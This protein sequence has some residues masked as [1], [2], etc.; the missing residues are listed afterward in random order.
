MTYEH[1]QPAPR[2]WLHAP[3][4]TATGSIAETTSGS[5]LHLVTQFSS[6]FPSHT[7]IPML[8][9][10][11]HT[12]TAL[13]ENSQMEALRHLSLEGRLLEKIG[14]IHYWGLSVFQ[15]RRKLQGKTQSLNDGWFYVVKTTRK[16]NSLLAAESWPCT[17]PLQSSYMI[18][19]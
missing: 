12:N 17:R 2:Q 8:L 18:S 1:K 19:T 13:S 10:M 15:G 11:K 3:Q 7:P 5:I 14:Y 16:Q 4:N 9:C 6:L